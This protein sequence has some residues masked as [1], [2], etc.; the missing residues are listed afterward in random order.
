MF[1]T[2]YRGGATL[3]KLGVNGDLG[4]SN[5][6]YKTQ[7]LNLYPN[8]NN[9]KLYFNHEFGEAE[10]EII[11][12]SG[13]LI[14]VVQLTKSLSKINVDLEQGTY[15]LRVRNEVSKFVVY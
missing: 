5:Q 7:T 12:L 1:V 15:F 10:A 13:K 9:G 4:F 2:N 11:S 3:F 14:H 6:E 8:A